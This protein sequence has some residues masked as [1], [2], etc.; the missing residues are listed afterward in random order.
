MITGTNDGSYLGFPP[1]GNPVTLR[2][3]A[4]QRFDADGLLTNMYVYFDNLTVLTQLGLFP[5]APDIEA[6][7]AIQRRFFEEIWNQGMLDLIDEIYTTDYVLHDPSGDIVGPDASKQSIAMYRVAFPDIHYAVEEQIAE[8]DMVVSRWTSTGT[9]EGE[10]MGF[11]P[12]GIRGQGVTGIRMERFADGKIAESWSDYDASGLLEQLGI[13]P[14]TREDYTWGVPSEVTGDPGEPEANKEIVRRVVE[15]LW[16]QRNIDLA[17]ELMAAEYVH[18]DPTNPTVADLEGYKQWYPTMVGAFPDGQLT[19]DDMVAEADLVAK[20][21]TVTGTHTGDE[22]FGIPATG[23][24]FAYTG[25]TIYRIADGKIV[26]TWWSADMMGLIQQLTPP[27]VPAKDYTNVFF[28]SLAPGLNMISLP[29]EPVEPYNARSFA[30]YIGAT[31]VIKYDEVLR[32]YEGFALNAP[33]DGFAI[34]GGKGYIVNSPEGGVVAF[35]GAA[36][37]NEPPVEMQA[38]PPVAGSDSAW[39]FLANGWVLDGEGMSVEDGNYTVTVRNLRTGTTATEIVDTSGYS[40]PVWADLSRKAVIEAGDEVEVAVIDSSGKLA[41]GPF[42]HEVTL[43]EI[44]NAVLDVRLRLGHII[45]EKSA[46]LQNYPNPFNPETWI[47][48]HLSDAAPVSIGIYNA[49]GQLIRTLD[50]GHRD[51][52]VYV[53]RSKAAYWDGKNE[54]GEAVASGIYFYSIAAGDFSAT[55]K[56]VIRK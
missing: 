30:E 34:E 43:D 25:I 53:S 22:A 11:P 4:L 46:L 9:H 27:E 31:V 24:Q 37:T 13:I 32:K 2:G 39:A 47:P 5:P 49:T 20:R 17:D 56:L 1:T 54:A 14:P 48:F 29:L 33:G 38:A 6:N 41:S 35:T 50:L 21:Y 26:E 18:H 3:A 8:G 19:I 55:R 23:N 36:W 40:A 28:M 45:P 42:V 15:E 7:K 52:G 10:L 16:N 51:A 12:T 44:R